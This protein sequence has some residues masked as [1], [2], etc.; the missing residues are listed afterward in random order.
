MINLHV[1]QAK[2]NQKKKKKKKEK[3]PEIIAGMSSVA[4]QAAKL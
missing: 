3:V 4:R 2:L 1:S